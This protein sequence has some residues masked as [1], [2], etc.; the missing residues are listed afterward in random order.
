MLY[1]YCSLFLFYGSHHMIV[2]YKYIRTFMD[3]CVCARAR[4]SSR[5]RQL[6]HVYDEYVIN[7]NTS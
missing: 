1:L 5:P 3:V 7:T 4:L 6:I 2:T